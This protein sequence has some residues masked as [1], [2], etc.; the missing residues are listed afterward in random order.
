MRV[1]SKELPTEFGQPVNNGAV[2]HYVITGNSEEVSQ[3][4]VEGVMAG[5]VFIAADT[6]STLMFD[7]KTHSWR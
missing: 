1:L 7:E 5:S 6:H 4:P 2:Y 3:L